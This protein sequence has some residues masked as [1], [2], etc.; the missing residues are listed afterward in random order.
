M[1]TG[2]QIGISAIIYAAM[3]LLGVYFD[4]NFSKDSKI[5]ILLMVAGSTVLF[6]TVN[7]IYTITRNGIPLQLF[8]F[9]KIIILE[10]IFNVLLTI[11]LYPLIKSVGYSLENIFKKKKILTRYF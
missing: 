6:E 5:T 9:L 7:Y 2:R 4:K 1:L 11:I 3:G 8:G 10:V